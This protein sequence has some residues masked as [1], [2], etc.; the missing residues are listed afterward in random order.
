MSPGHYFIRLSQRY[1][2]ALSAPTAEGVL[3][4]TDLRLRPSGSKGPLA[5]H[6][7]SFETY[8]NNEAWT[9]EHMALT[10]L[11]AV[12]GPKAL[13]DKVLA[14]T[15][16]VLCKQ[17]DPDKLVRE[18]YDMR[19]RME[20]GKGD[21]HPWAIKMRRGGLVDLEF[22]AQYLQLRHAHDHP[23]VLSPTT[24]EV[25][26]NLA[27]VGILDDEEAEFLANS[28]SF[29]LAL[30]AMLRLTTEGPFDPE[31]ASED[32]QK[33][34]ANAGK[35]DDFASLQD[36]MEMTATRIKEIYDRVVAAPAEKIAPTDAPQ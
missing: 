29:W 25:F 32:L 18:V 30:Q 2:N 36:K 9:W 3:F 15:N 27:T 31:K 12:Y 8:Q 22:I 14:T 7:K 17:R 6:F 33:M 13:C 11:R 5:T 16:D 21:N 23:E 4:E 24:R 20:A 28:A 1:I 10:R 34:L 26:K 19:N 35:C